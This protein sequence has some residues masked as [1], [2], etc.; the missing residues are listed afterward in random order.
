M[1]PSV[2]LAAAIAVLLRPQWSARNRHQLPRGPPAGGNP[3]AR[4]A[5][6]HH[7]CRSGPLYRSG[8]DHKIS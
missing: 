7:H 2:P 4:S 5:L 3:C 1:L 8:R 6:V